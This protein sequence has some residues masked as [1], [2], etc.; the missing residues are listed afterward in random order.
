MSKHKSA[1]N[2]KNIIKNSIKN[3]IK[4]K[5]ITSHYRVLATSFMVCKCCRARFSWRCNVSRVDRRFSNRAWSDAFNLSAWSAWSPW[6][7]SWS[8]CSFWIFSS[9][10]CS[11]SNLLASVRLKGLGG[12]FI[13]MMKKGFSALPHI[14]VP[15]NGAG[16]HQHKQQQHSTKKKGPRCEGT[17]KTLLKQRTKTCVVKPLLTRFPHVLQRVFQMFRQRG[18]G[19]GGV[20]PDQPHVQQIQIKTRG[21]DTARKNNKKHQPKQ[22]P[23]TKKSQTKTRAKQK[24]AP[25]KRTKKQ[26]H[27]WLD[28]SPTLGTVRVVVP[29][30]VVAQHV[31]FFG[32]DGDRRHLLGHGGQQLLQPTSHPLVPFLLPEGQGQ[33]MHVTDLAQHPHHTRPWLLLCVAWAVAVHVHPL[34]DGRFQH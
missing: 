26:K 22:Q 5:Q 19:V 1:N 2:I 29:L 32:G 25:K 17:V 4:N 11:T 23:N 8:V 20:V 10:D 18:P 7:S 14:R 24:E 28:R 31:L 9:N 3:Y 33:T 21:H 30:A 34:L 15:G 12:S 13:L 27:R 6:P 16:E